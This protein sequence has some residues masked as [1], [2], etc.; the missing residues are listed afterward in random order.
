M[1]FTV[2]AFSTIPDIETAR[3]NFQLEDLG[4]KEVAK[5]LF[6]QRK[7]RT[8]HSEKLNWDQLQI[9]SVTLATYAVDSVEIDTHTQLELPEPGLIEK[10]YAALEVSGRLVSW[11]GNVDALPLLHFRCMK[12]QLAYPGYWRAARNGRQPHTD[13]RDRLAPSTTEVP[14]LDALARRFHYP[15][16]LGQSMDTVWEAFL[17]D[18][19]REIARFS[20]YRALNTY[21]LALDL[22]T[23]HGEMTQKDAA[24]ARAMLRDYLEKHAEMKPYHSAFLDAW[25]ATPRKATR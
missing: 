15:G 14:P 9:V 22:M 4:D 23:L 13:L 18:D 19:W 6:H 8:G 24:R 25:K 1:R 16:M 3:K 10:L 21:L 5:V 7:Q 2:F 20:D 11:N 17:G 12:H